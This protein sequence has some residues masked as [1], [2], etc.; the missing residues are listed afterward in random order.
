MNGL[1]ASIAMTLQMRRVRADGGQRGFQRRRRVVAEQEAQARV[2]A[3]AAVVVER[4]ELIEPQAGARAGADADLHG[5]DL[6]RQLAARLE[7]AQQRPE[8]G[9]P[10][11]RPL[12][13]GWRRSRR[14][15]APP[16]SRAWRA[17]PRRPAAARTARLNGQMMQSRHGLNVSRHDRAVAR[18]RARAGAQRAHGGGELLVGSWP[19]RPGAGRSRSR[20][21][22]AAVRPVDGAPHHDR[23]AEARLV[24]DP[25]EVDAQRRERVRRRARS[26]RAA[27]SAAP[28]T[29]LVSS[30]TS[31][32]FGSADGA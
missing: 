21:A 2:V 10:N 15:A 25:V 11:R 29:R 7:V 17:P 6:R 8:V 27:P 4:L 13:D 32:P 19:G 3:A 22:A 5:V 28:V 16:R 31:V 23:V 30:A 20:S 26:R 9:R 12:P 14:S 18:R 24:L 1:V